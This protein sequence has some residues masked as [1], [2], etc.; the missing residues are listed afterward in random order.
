MQQ[1]ASVLGSYFSFG[2]DDE[3]D[4]VKDITSDV[5][6]TIMKAK[7]GGLEEVFSQGIWKNTLEDMLVPDWTLLYFK[8]KV[9]LP[10]DAWQAML[11][12]TKLG[13]SGVSFL[14]DTCT[15]LVV[16]ILC[17]SVCLFFKLSVS[18]SVCGFVYLFVDLFVHFDT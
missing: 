6:N 1:I 16:F 4:E 11:N 2:T 13:R 8:L 17:L 18:L 7:K 5:A 10:D 14:Q 15:M 12:V 3:Q 9:C